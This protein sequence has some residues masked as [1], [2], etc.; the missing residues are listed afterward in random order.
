M[1][2]QRSSKKY[3]RRSQTEL[4]LSPLL[5]VYGAEWFPSNLRLEHAEYANADADANTNSNGADANVN[6]HA[7]ANFNG[8]NAYGADADADSDS[9][10]TIA[11]ANG[12]NQIVIDATKDV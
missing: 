1:H 4:W 12:T 10:G 8:A 5:S 11:N 3:D 9:N 6:A 7:D 2:V